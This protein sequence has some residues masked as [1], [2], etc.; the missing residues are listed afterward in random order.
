VTLVSC[1]KSAFITQLSSPA[2]QTNDDDLCTRQTTHDHCHVGSQLQHCTNIDLLHERAYTPAGSQ[3]LPMQQ[4]Q[5][6]MCL[7]TASGVSLYTAFIAFRRKLI[8]IPTMFLV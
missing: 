5:C 6:A 7:L 4:V 1:Q 3:A 2:V 8:F